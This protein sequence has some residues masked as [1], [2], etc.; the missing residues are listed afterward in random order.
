[1]MTRRDNLDN[2]DNDDCDDQCYDI[3]RVVAVTK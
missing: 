1:M 3:N 2:V